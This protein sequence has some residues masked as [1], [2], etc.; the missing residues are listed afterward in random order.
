MVSR[1]CQFAKAVG[2]LLERMLSWVEVELPRRVKHELDGVRVVS[3]LSVSFCGLHG[4][5]DPM[6]G[7]SVLPAKHAARTKLLS[8][9]GVLNVSVKLC[10][11][12]SKD[13]LRTLQRS[14]PARCGR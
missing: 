10:P 14:L 2:L 3:S 4:W 8:V 12:V 6:E 9:E 7:S 5:C 11:S 1:H 13:F